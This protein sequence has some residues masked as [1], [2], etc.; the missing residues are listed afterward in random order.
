MNEFNVD[1]LK[2]LYVPASGSHKGQN[3]KLLIIGGSVLFHAASLWALQVAS[4]I[5]DMVFYSSVPQNNALVEKEKEEFRNGIIVPRNKIEHY[6]EEA[7]CILIGP[8]LPRE[9]GVEEGDDDTKELTER[10]FKAYPNKKWVVDGGSLQVIEPEILPKTAIITPHKHEFQQLFKIE[11]TAENAKDMVQKYDITILLKGEKDIVCDSQNSVLISGGNAGMTKG[12]T[13]DVLAG[14][15]SAL[16]CKNEAFLS[17]EAGSYIN[18]KAGD[19]L[20]RKMGIYFNASDLANEIP[21]VMK[22]LLV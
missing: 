17:A 2:K 9:D 22:G 16:Y 10:L 13:G 12:G 14:L 20:A 4:R 1:D 5:V 3:G 15:V 11:P 21:A 6:I 19:S 8:G 7:D 18:K